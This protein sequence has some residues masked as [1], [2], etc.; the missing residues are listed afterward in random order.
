MAKK[1]KTNFQLVKAVLNQL[2][3]DV[4]DAYGDGDKADAAIKKKLSE[5]SSAYTQLSDSEFPPIDYGPPETRFAYVY[6]YVATHADFVYQMLESTRDSLADDLLKNEKIVVS[7]L[8]GGP[9][10][11]LVGLLQF[12]IE[13]DSS[14]IRTLTAY[15]CDREQAWAD[16]WTEIGE[17]V[18][19][20]LRLNV[21]FQPL[22][23]TSAES[24][25]KQK[26]FLSADLFI[27]CYFASEVARLGDAADD[28]WNE[29]AA[30]SKSGALM[31]ILDNDHKFFEGFI[32]EKIRQKA[33]KLLD[34][35]KKDLTPSTREEKS[36]LGDHLSRY[37]R[38]PKLKGHVA[39]WVLQRK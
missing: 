22:D 5:L 23:V 2:R 7:C 36:D 21:N 1:N 20:A 3:A 25:S 38:M 11:E 32:K 9:G 34:G 27:L 10:S 17:E 28:F 31:F 30:K 4:R 29:L 18:P 15:L 35:G 24:W 16:C 12:L 26:K 19:G 37:S 8:G 33:W 14:S 13:E 39:Y 6:S